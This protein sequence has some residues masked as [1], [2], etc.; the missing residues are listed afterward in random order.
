MLVI[1]TECIQLWNTLPTWQITSQCW[2]TKPASIVGKPIK[3]PNTSRNSVLLNELSHLPTSAADIKL[4]TAKDPALAQVLWA[5]LRGWPSGKPND[6]DLVPYLERRNELSTVDG[7]ILW[8]SRVV[9]PKVGREMVIEA[10][11]ETHPGIVKMKTLV[12]NYVWWL[13][14]DEQL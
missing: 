6:P 3:C 14:M 13:K 9:I 5:T 2:C 11:H 4:W 8:S 10:L 12:R 7:C 1:D